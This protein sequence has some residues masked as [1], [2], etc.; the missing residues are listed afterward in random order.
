MQLSGLYPGVTVDDV[1]A[2][3]GW[4]LKMA[5]EIEE[6][7]APSTEDLRLI[8]EELDPNGMYR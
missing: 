1:Q 8:R 7:I 4:P 6:V 2:E 5:Q 3:V